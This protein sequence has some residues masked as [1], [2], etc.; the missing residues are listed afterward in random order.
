MDDTEKAQAL[1]KIER[2]LRA[3]LLE[4]SKLMEQTI[5]HN[6][7]LVDF[8]KHI[9]T[10]STG[11]IVLIATLYEK[12]SPAKEARTALPLAIIFLLTSLIFGVL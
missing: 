12:L 4:A 1:E 10:L 7:Q 9:T 8:A 3:V 11:A 5:E 6:R 2:D